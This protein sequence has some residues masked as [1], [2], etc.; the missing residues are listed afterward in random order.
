VAQSGKT[1]ADPPGEWHNYNRDLPSS[2]YSPLSQIDRTNVGKLALE[3]QW[4]PDSGVAPR[5]FKNESTPLMIHGML[6]FSTALNRDVVAADAQTGRQK[7]RWHQDED[8]RASIAPRRGSGRGVSYWT[9]GKEERIFVVTPGYRLIALDA[10]TG[11]M[12]ES[13]GTHGALD[14]KMQIGVPLDPT[15]AVIGSSSPPLV[16]EDI[17]VIG[18]ALEVGSRPVSYKNVPGRILAIDAR[19]GKL[20]WRFNTIPQAGEFGVETW[21]NNSWTYTGNT[22]AWAPLTLDPARGWLYLPIEAATGDY[23]GGHRLGDNLFSTTLLCVDVRTGKRV[24]HYQI[25]HH[26]IW[27]YDNTAAPI[28]ADITV[29][30][31]KIQSVVQLTKQ[32]FAYVFDRVTGK[33]VWPIVERPVPPADIPGERAAPTQPF[34]TR[35]PAFDR[36]GVSVDDLIDFTPELR[37]QALEIIKPYHIGPLF[38]PATL[39]HA[40][41]GTKGLISLPG[42]LGGADWEGGAVDPETGVVYVGSHTAPSIL[43][44]ARDSAR[45]DMNVVNL[46]AAPPTVQGLPLLKPPYSR[47]TALD[48]NRGAFLWQMPSGDT[49][50]RVKNNP[51]LKGIV[52]PTTGGF[53]RPVVLV[54]KTLLFAAEGWGGAPVLRALDKQTGEVLSAYRVHSGNAMICRKPAISCSPPSGAFRKFGAC[55]PK[56]GR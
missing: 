35:P 6:Y 2:R 38:T 44:M 40:P 48:L 11:A 8:D 27:D 36:Q 7:W 55:A 22:G 29:D 43:A 20:R 46:G 5:E 45:S 53:A 24:W 3:F 39:Q 47:I 15:K 37:A 41:D 42:S 19:T 26:D 21:E 50:D 9:D 25:V 23:Y 10:K 1:A 54:T 28:L 14:L 49:P 56:D 30:G 18:P 51:A 34:P 33:P 52:I 17:L 31:K 32:S 12:I 4:R 16:F 13:F